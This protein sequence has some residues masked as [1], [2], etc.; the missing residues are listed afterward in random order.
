VIHTIVNLGETVAAAIQGLD[1]PLT[2]WHEG[3]S[4]LARV[5]EHL[6]QT[7]QDKDGRLLGELLDELGTTAAGDAGSSHGSGLV[8]VNVLDGKDQLGIYA[9][10]STALHHAAK[11]GY[12]SAIA[13][14]TAH[15]AN[16][17]AKATDGQTPVAVAQAAGH[18][19]V[20]DALV[21]AGA[22]SRIK[23]GRRKP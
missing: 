20:V 17:N 18:H 9:G 12:V 11:T 19:A 22:K 7:G 8:D 6:G 2:P 16:V 10:H 23:K 1:G 21:A 5:V 3:I 13:V 14:L 4:A 15:G